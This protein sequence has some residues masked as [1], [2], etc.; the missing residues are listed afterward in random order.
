MGDYSLV[1][2]E[3]QAARPYYRLNDNPSIYWYFDSQSG[4]LFTL[5]TSVELMYNVSWWMGNWK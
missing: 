5:V 3:V 2:N 4:E 1:E